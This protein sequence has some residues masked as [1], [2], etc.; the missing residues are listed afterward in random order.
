MADI[1]SLERDVS[2]LQSQLRQQRSEAERMRRELQEQNRRNLSAAREEMRRAI[3]Q[4]DRQAQEKYEALLRQYERTLSEDAGTQL[5]RTDA[6]Y[7]RLLEETRRSQAQLEQKNAELE[8]AVEELR[9][10]FGAREQFGRGEAEARLRDAARTFREIERKPHRK[11]MP[12]R[13]KALYNTLSDGQTLCQSGMYDAA[14]A[15]AIS[16]DAGLQRLGFA[17][18]DKAAEWQW[19]YD[20]HQMKLTD[21]ELKLSGEEAA[22]QAFSGQTGEGETAKVLRQAEMDFWSRGVSAQVREVAAQRRAFVNDVEAKGREMYWRDPDSVTTDRLKEWTEQIDRAAAD[23][24]GMRQLYKAR[25]AASCRRADMGEAIIDFLCDEIN[26]VWLESLSG[27]PQ[28]DDKAVAAPEF[29]RYMAVHGRPEARE[30]VR[31]RLRLVF[32][33]ATG[34]RIYL[35]IV[36]V[37]E[38]GKVENRMILHIDFG[39]SEQPAYSREL[40]AHIREA[41]GSEDEADVHYAADPEELKASPIRAFRETAGELERI[42]I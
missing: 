11:F 17:L 13:L 9:K 19:Q 20:L 33:N 32:E 10:Q 6:A 38:H 36:P 4:H 40:A 25:Y 21:L 37:E 15:V 28:A 31:E 7:R 35:Y 14:A 18:D 16:T 26:L 8:Q 5:A 41:V 39:G 2:S 22:W 42:K 3:E 27:F 1:R 23:L 12:R 30:D 29:R 34:S 24:D